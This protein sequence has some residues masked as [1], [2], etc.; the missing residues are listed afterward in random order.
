[1]A[2]YK[3]LAVAAAAAVSY[4]LGSVSFGIIFTRLY[5]GAEVRDMGSGNT[6]MTNV[7][8]TA[9]AVPGFL[10]GAGDFAKGALAMFLSGWLFGLAGMDPYVGK[11]LAAA[12]ALAGHLFPIFFQFRGGKGVM[13][14]FGILLMLDYRILIAV[15]LIF[16]AAFVFC[17]TVSLSALISMTFMP[18]LN[19]GAAILSG[20]PGF[21]MLFSTIFTALITSLLYF[22]LRD[23]IKRLREGSEPKLVIKKAK[24]EKSP[25]SGV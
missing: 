21:D 14:T 7:L 24:E 5:A 12:C 18:L 1:M 22:T 9:G 16:A 13:T 23:N 25:P 8:R 6:G 2:L 17:R 4:L 20:T 15:T 3:I 10:T 11:C 19:L